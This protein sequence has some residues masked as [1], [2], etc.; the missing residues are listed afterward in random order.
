MAWAQL[1]FTLINDML[2]YF[3]A[4]ANFVKHKKPPDIQYTYMYVKG[5]YY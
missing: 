1:F 3:I 5:N 4:I 2:I